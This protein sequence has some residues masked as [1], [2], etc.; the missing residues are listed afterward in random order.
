MSHR[1]WM[2]L[3]GIGAF[4]CVLVVVLVGSTSARLTGH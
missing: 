2:V 3:S 4:L 1:R